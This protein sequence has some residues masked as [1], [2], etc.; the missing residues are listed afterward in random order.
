MAD[1]NS[2][3]EIIYNSVLCLSVP[4]INIIIK[5]YIEPP[6]RTTSLL[7]L[8]AHG[9]Q[10]AYLTDAPKLSFFKMKYQP[11]SSFFNI[12]NPMTIMINVTTYYKTH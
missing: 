11:Y 10:D 5:Y 1:H 6:Q 12:I 4:T 8:V 7:Q 2:I 3:F 9:E